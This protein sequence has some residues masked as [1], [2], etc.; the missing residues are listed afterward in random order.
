MTKAATWIFFGSLAIYSAILVGV[1][2]NTSQ[3]FVRHYF[4]DIDG[5]RPFFAI[6]TTLSTMLLASAGV[7]LIFT[8][9]AGHP[10]LPA[11]T[12]FL[13]WSQAGMLGFLA[14]DDRFQLHEALAYRLN[15]GD[16]FIMT[17]WAV[18][19]A[20]F[21]L[22]FARRA[23]IPLKAFAFVAVGGAFF[24]LMMLFDAILPH[25]MF[26]RLSIE[27]LAKSWAAAC[28]FGAAWCLARFHIG[29]VAQATTLQHAL[30][31]FP[32]LLGMLD[33]SPLAPKRSAQGEL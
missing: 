2:A 4:S 15:I 11:K 10:D 23:Q 30:E 21:I 17:A 5:G 28:F 27:D 29:I 26:L 31:R 24:M 14:F 1:E 22:A 7:L 19:E 9:C 8:A 16:H 3:D 33:R 25:D 20:V 12:T 13:L 32:V 18:I 6:N